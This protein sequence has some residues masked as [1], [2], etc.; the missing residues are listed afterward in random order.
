MPVTFLLWDHDGVLVDTERW[1]FEATK[2]VLGGIG[3]GLSK[4]IY[5][6]FMTSDAAWMRERVRLNSSEL[7]N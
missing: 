5:L 2:L 6:E 3:V 7:S 1:Y 4:E